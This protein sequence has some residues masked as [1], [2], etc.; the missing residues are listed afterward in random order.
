M[1]MSEVRAERLLGAIEP[2]IRASLSPE[3]EA[4]IRAAVGTTRWSDHPVD[5]RLSLPMPGL[6]FYMALVGGRE[7][8]NGERRRHE[9]RLHPL[10][11]LGNVAVFALLTLVL[12][13]GLIGAAALA[14][15]LISL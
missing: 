9:R 4:A 15:G 1:L 13:L 6:H 5:L 2:E 11:S 7:R 8:R 3:Q 12:G 10:L 14:G